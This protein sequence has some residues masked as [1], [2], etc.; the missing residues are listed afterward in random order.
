[1]GAAIDTVQVSVREIPKF[2]AA[3]SDTQTGTALLSWEMAAGETVEEGFE[4]WRKADGGDWELLAQTEENRYTDTGLENGKTYSYYVC[5]A[6]AESGTGSQEG[7]IILSG[8]SVVR[9]VTPSADHVQP[10]A[11]LN[12]HAAPGDGT[13]L[14]Y[15]DEPADEPEACGRTEKYI[16]QE[17]YVYDG[18]SDWIDLTPYYSWIRRLG[19]G[20]NGAVISAE[21]KNSRIRVTA[22]NQGDKRGES[23]PLQLSFTDEDLGQGSGEMPGVV[24]PGAESGDGQVTLKWKKPEE[25]DLKIAFFII[26]RYR[27]DAAYSGGYDDIASIFVG[28]GK[29]GTSTKT[30]F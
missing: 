18:D 7:R 21:Y 8:R 12:V 24:W 15:W 5:L 14:V 13:I 2:E 9:S 1:M 26:G 11:P 22:V 3:L 6:Q 23:E 19:T 17:E 4:I 25:G 30:D 28:V 10:G 20:S 27:N 29:R 16:I